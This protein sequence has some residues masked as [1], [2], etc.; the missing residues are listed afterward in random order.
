[1]WVKEIFWEMKNSWV[2]KLRDGKKENEDERIVTEKLQRN[3]GKGSQVQ[4]G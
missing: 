1:M 2:G 4:N 3:K